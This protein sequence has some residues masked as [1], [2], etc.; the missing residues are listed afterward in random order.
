MTK[1]ELIEE[2]KFLKSRL[3]DINNSLNEL[4]F[5][6]VSGVEGRIVNLKR[7]NSDI[8]DRFIDY[9]IKTTR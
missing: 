2:N 3:N 9:V 1:K 8:R 7:K 5:C 4:G 6:G